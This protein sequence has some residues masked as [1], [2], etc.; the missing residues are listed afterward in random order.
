MTRII[1]GSAKN[2]KLKAPRIED[3]RAVQDV[4]KGSLFSIIGT[5][6][7]N[8]T[9]LDLYSG[10]GNL[11]LEALSRE[12]K[13]CDFVDENAKAIKT[14]EEN[15]KNCNFLGNSKIFHKDCVKYVA[16]TE[17]D[18]DYIFVD[19]FYHVTSHKFL[20]KN[21]DEI[22]KPSGMIVFFHGDNL[23]MSKLIADTNLQIIDERRFGNSY[24]T[25]LKHSKQDFS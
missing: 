11:G 12:A 7:E 21:L 18:Y 13:W 19:P 23:N 5:D 17:K 4:A 15:I 25:L 16:N 9:C 2:K 3:Y 8:A 14:I 24:F 1:T 10:S 6:I 22:L 20:V